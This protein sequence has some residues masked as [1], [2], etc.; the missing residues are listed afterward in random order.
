MSNETT[1]NGWAN[2]S[3]WNIMLWLDN[4]ESLY[5]FYQSQ[6]AS[7]KARGERITAMRAKVIARAA[8]G[9]RTP[10]GISTYAKC[11]D[12]KAIAEAMCE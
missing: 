11:I 10:D 2:R 1:Y 3:T 9:S 4:D 7:L 6:V 5:R 8:I 12:W